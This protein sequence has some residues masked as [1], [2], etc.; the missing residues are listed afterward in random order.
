MP[1]MTDYAPG[2]PCW[3]DLATDDVAAT[4]TF[5]AGLFGWTRTDLG[6]DAGG[7]GFFEL[8]GRMVAGVGPKQDPAQP[9]AWMTYVSVTDADATAEKVTANGGTVVAPPMDVM[10]AGRMAVFADPTGAFFSAWQ[11][12]DHVG[13][14]LANQAGA[15]AWNELNSRDLAAAK[16]FYPAVFGWSAKTEEMAP[17][18]SYTSWQRGDATIGGMLAMPEMVPAEV[19]SYWLTYFGTPNVDATVAKAQKLG[20][21]VMLAGTDIPPGRFAV[22]ADPQGAPFAV[23]EFPPSAS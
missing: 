1:E 14:G 8:D 15:L 10:E 13:A 23:F 22:L 3:V 21:Q 12:R 19:P 5:Y 2:T 4:E 18:M 7:Y 17:G 16:A 20:G 9:A 6:P 11:P